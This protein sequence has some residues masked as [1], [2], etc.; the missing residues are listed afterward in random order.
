MQVWKRSRRLSRC[1]FIE[2]RGIASEQVAP[3]PTSVGASREEHL[4]GEKQKGIHSMAT[5]CRGWLRARRFPPHCAMPHTQ[6]RMLRAALVPDSVFRRQY[7]MG[8]YATARAH[9]F[10][11]PRL[12]PLATGKTMLIVA[13]R[14]RQSR[15]PDSCLTAALHEAP[16]NTSAANSRKPRRV[17]STLAA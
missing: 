8:D 4:L 17:R 16:L 5:T 1:R 6:V 2:C 12:N 11:C 13:S 10:T 7:S 3:H 15:S 14:W 9:P